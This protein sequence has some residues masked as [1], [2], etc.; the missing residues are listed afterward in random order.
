MR[1]R[2]KGSQALSSSHQFWLKDYKHIIPGRHYE[3][4]FLSLFGECDTRKLYDFITISP[5]RVRLASP[6]Y[7]GSYNQIK[8]PGASHKGQ[9]IRHHIT[10]NTVHLQYTRWQRE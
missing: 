1:L 4:I 6:L 5:A 8:H 3:R 9:L 7:I 10:I 2:R